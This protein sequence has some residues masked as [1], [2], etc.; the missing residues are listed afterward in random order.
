MAE[1][2]RKLIQLCPRPPPGRQCDSRELPHLSHPRPGPNPA[3]FFSP[4]LTK[5][6]LF[7]LF[8]L[9]I[10]LYTNTILNFTGGSVV[11]NLPALWKTLVRSLGWEDPLEKG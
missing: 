11:K 3:A 5:V 1:I 4:T 2:Q 10:F 9:K 6:F 8:D 7:S